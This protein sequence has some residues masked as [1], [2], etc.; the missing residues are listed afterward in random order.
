MFE[1]FAADD[2]LGIDGHRWP[3]REVVA[4]VIDQEFSC[5]NIGVV[6]Q[7]RSDSWS[8]VSPRPANLLGISLERAGNIDVNDRLDIR[9]IDPHPKSIRGT[10]DTQG[11]GGKAVLNRASL[12]IG[13]AGMVR[14]SVDATLGQYRCRQLR[15]FSCRRV[16]EC[17]LPSD[18]PREELELLRVSP[19]WGDAQFDVRAVEPGDDDA[20]LRETEEIDDI[21]ANFWSCGC[22]EGRDWRAPGLLIATTAP[23]RSTFETP[24]VRPKIVSPV[25]HTVRF[26][27]H[28]S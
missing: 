9:P 15:L 5:S 2:F 11:A 13:K 26:V 10:H 23:F 3:V 22:C 20:R 4:G 24:I 17:P 18:E 7:Q 16:H 1:G 8:A 12:S 28:E 19:N 27:N 14:G 21:V 25:R 6:P